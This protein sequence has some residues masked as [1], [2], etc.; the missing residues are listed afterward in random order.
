M[1]A[2]QQITVQ[3]MAGG[4]SSRMGRDKA[5]VQL[6]GQTLAMRALE[7]WHGWG[8]KILYSVGSR[9]APVWLPDWAEPV[10]DT[11][12]ECG[13]MGGLEAGL[14]CCVTPYLLLCAVDLPFVTPK[15][16]ERLAAAIGRADSCAFC[17]D[18]MEEPLFGLYRAE[19][20]LPVVVRRLE[21][22]Q[23]RMRELFSEWNSVL[24]PTTEEEMFRNL[25]TQQD[26][27]QARQ[28]LEHAANHSR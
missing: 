9:P 12:P 23:F 16:G 27:E 8:A 19:S 4:R 10:W 17:R 22:G 5:L 20:C 6:G 18:G 3:I 13:P 25:N 21:Q 14:L 11:H 15:H 24:I 2:K 7:Q 26:L 1:I 28:L